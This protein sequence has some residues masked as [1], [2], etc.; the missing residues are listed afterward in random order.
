MNDDKSKEI[1][2]SVYCLAYNCVRF[3]EKSIQGMLNQKLNVEYKI[4]IHDDASV[5]GTAKIIKRYA[6]KYP[7]KIYAI[8]QSENQYSQG[9]NIYN[10]YI[11]P[12]I[13][14]DY[15][16]ICEGDDKWIDENKLQTQYDYMEKHPEC[17]LCTHNTIWN[18]LETGN[19]RKFND[20]HSVHTLTEK[21]VFSEWCV[22]TSSYFYR[23]KN[24]K[25]SGNRYWFGDYM[26][27]TW[28]FYLGEVVCL[29]QIMSVY[30]HG[31]SNGV[32]SNILCL[33]KNKQI[34]KR[35]EYIT[36]LN[37]Y[38]EITKYKY[39]EYVEKEILL[40]DFE[41]IRRKCHDT[42]LDSNSKAETINSAKKV[43]S[44]ECYRGFINEKRGLS[45]FISLYIY[46]GYF[47]YIL[48]KFIIKKAI[49][50][51]HWLQKIK[52]YSPI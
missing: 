2:V 13:E 30:N 36:Y 8:L 44:H 20:W 23:K 21:E 19:H 51:K 45:R 34:D 37:E 4:I 15:I 48:W 46:E 32:M 50:Y 28:A 11:D 49:K 39:N 3:I 33:G 38:N 40:I 5:D 9:V 52:K 14:G 43:K 7:D 35:R 16:A 25:W 29:P 27:L 12:N 18:D 22:H 1:R 17:S 41:C 24:K 26:R 10:E 6:E 31:N 47:F 42:I